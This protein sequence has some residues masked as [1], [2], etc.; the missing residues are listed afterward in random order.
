[1][2]F[3][4]LFFRTQE[5]LIAYLATAIHEGAHLFM[6]V[7][8]NE[9]PQEISFGIFG[10]SLKTDYIESST[11]K[12]LIS[13]AGPVFSL[14]VF[15]YM[16]AAGIVFDIKDYC[17]HFFTLSNFSLG[18]IN[19]LPLSPLDGGAMVK[20]FLVRIMGI[21]GGS[22]VYGILSSVFCLFF[23]CCNLYLFLSEVFNPS[24]FLILIFSLWGVRYEKLCNLVEKRRVLSGDIVP[25]QR[26]KFLSCDC[27]SELLCLAERIG[28][29][30]TLIIASFCKERFFGEINQ[31]EITEGIKKYGALCTVREYIEKTG[32]R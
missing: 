15:L 11:K 30:Y 13:A 4:C 24:L 10:A 14:S 32:N 1:M 6:C 17:Y 19:L 2:F 5:L 23:V 22:K 9:R 3:S 26:L 12:I 7:Y 28:G 27:E 20:A 18:I 31:F 8:L 16:Y 29:D 21:I 25:K